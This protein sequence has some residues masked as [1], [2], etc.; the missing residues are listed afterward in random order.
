MCINSP[1]G[2]ALFVLKTTFT[3]HSISVG[4]RVD[5]EGGLHCNTSV[6]LVKYAH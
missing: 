6:D 1:A 3:V 4:L 2:T 5:F